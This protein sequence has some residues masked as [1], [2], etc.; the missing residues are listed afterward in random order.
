MPDASTA[1]VRTRLRGAGLRVTPQRTLVLEIL[2]NGSHL[3][4]MAIHE[5]AAKARRGLSL[6]TVYR[7]L[8]ALT[9]SGLIEQ[10]YLDSDHSREYYEAVRGP[11]HHHMTCLGC[12]EVIE[13]ETRRIRQLRSELE[14]MEGWALQR[15]CLCIE[16]YCPKCQNERRMIQVAVAAAPTK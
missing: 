5:R 11:E 1:N 12:G 9:E 4:A 8:A 15:T 7:T 2:E 3:D 16:G 14:A 10:R 13:F 6:A